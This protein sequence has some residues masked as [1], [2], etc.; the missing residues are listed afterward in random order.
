MSCYSAGD[1]AGHEA[2]AA[3]VCPGEKLLRGQWWWW[4]SVQP[5]PPP[6]PG[7]HGPLCHQHHQVRAQPPFLYNRHQSN[8]HLLPYVA[9]NGPLRHFFTIYI[10]P[11][12]T[13]S[14]T[15]HSM[16]L[17]VIDT[18]RSEHSRHFRTVE[19]VG[20]VVGWGGSGNLSGLVGCKWEP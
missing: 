7:T 6:L 16:G 5:P 11:T 9:L 1:G 3:E 13:S 14:P 8:L 4:P 15:W 20:F 10:R 19:C 12:S 18:T 2:V 17:Y